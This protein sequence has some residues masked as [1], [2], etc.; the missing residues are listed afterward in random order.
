MPAPIDIVLTQK[1]QQQQQQQQQVQQQQQAASLAAGSLGRDSLFDYY[2]L[3]PAFADSSESSSEDDYY[4]HDLEANFCRDFSCC[5]LIL[6]DLHDLLQHYEECHVRFEED[7][8]AA[9]V[10]GVG[11]LDGWQTDESRPGS[12]RDVNRSFNNT[13]MLKRQQQQMTAAAAAALSNGISLSDV[14]GQQT[15]AL[16]QLPLDTVSPALDTALLGRKRTASAMTGVEAMSNKRVSLGSGMAASVQPSSRMVQPQQQQTFVDDELLLAALLQLGGEE[17]FGDALL[18]QQ[19]LLMNNNRASL[20]SPM[21]PATASPVAVTPASMPAAIAPQP[22]AP[23]A[24][25]TPVGSLAAQRAQLAPQPVKP[26]QLHQQPMMANGTLPTARG[27]G[28]TA[29]TPVGA[30]PTRMARDPSAER[31]YRCSVPGCDKSYKNANGLKYHNLHGHCNGNAA[32]SAHATHSAG[33]AAHG[34]THA[35]GVAGNEPHRSQIKPYRC[36]IPDC[37]KS[38]KNL[39]GLKYHVEHAHPGAIA[40]P[41]GKKAHVKAAA[42]VIAQAQERLQMATIKAVVVPAN[43]VANLNFGNDTSAATGG[44]TIVEGTVGMQAGATASAAAMNANEVVD[45]M[46]VDDLPLAQPLPASLAC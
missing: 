12:P 32:A 44:M 10:T 37:G 28:V 34:T 21:A 18:L 40:L 35:H 43:M 24:I 46:T 5:G 8:P 26:Q 1:Q 42:A 39:N 11:Y 20:T 14:Y 25:V 9:L 6:R 30:T 38:Y 23:A 2:D 22:I 16:G 31:P 41:L 36:T 15:G 13:A 45:V 19:Q 29:A 33:M 3:S 4:P 27:V 17:A 7:D